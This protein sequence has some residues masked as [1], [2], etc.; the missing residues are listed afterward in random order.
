MGDIPGGGKLARPQWGIG[1]L[2][3][4]LLPEPIAIAIR[5]QQPERGPRQHRAVE[6]LV[7]LTQ[8]GPFLPRKAAPVN[9]AAER[10]ITL[11]IRPLA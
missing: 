9:Q 5:A 11:G 4:Q 10:L 3:P 7:P 6:R 1:D 2:V 8:L